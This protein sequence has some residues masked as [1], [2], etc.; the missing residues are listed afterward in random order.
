MVQIVSGQDDSK[1]NSANL[2]KQLSAYLSS[3]EIKRSKSL[4]PI[5]DKVVP[6]SLKLAYKSGGLELSYA[7]KGPLTVKE[8]TALESDLKSKILENLLGNFQGGLLGTDSL[9]S[10]LKKVTFIPVV[11][12]SPGTLVKPTPTDGFD[13]AKFKQRF[14]ALLANPDTG[15]LASVKKLNS[16]VK[17]E[18][19]RIEWIPGKSLKFFYTPLSS[20]PLSD[21]DTGEVESIIKSRLV[22][23]VL[24]NYLGGMVSQKTFDE[25]SPLVSVEKFRNPAVVV[26]IESTQDWYWD[27]QAIYPRPSNTQLI[28]IRGQVHPLRTPRVGIVEQVA[29]IDPNLPSARAYG[30]AM[31]ALKAN[32][33]SLALALFN[34]L[35]K[36]EANN[37]VYWFLKAVASYDLGRDAEGIEAAKKAE[38]LVGRASVFQT[39]GSALESIQGPRREFL[40][41][42]VTG[43]W[44]P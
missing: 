31:D 15:S 32:R 19:D 2:N 40:K 1:L 26:G 37:P 29:P 3:S 16:L 11:E 4:D 12:A 43:I 30:M 34:H 10:I 14:G 28:L 41:Y 44:I 36:E 18:T 42:A 39:V 35:I 9:E 24:G 17:L 13:I 25:I 7:P 8:K 5:F 27:P 6:G 23:T 20:G 33:S 38:S 21:E 22:P